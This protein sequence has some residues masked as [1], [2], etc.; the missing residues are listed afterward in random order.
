MRYA[1]HH[2]RP[3]SA[4]PFEL[5]R[6][7]SPNSLNNLSNGS[8]PLAEL[9]LKAK[10]S[11]LAKKAQTIRSSSQDSAGLVVQNNKPAIVKSE[12]TTQ[13]QSSELQS[14][15]VPTSTFDEGANAAS[16]LNSFT[17]RTVG[18]GSASS[19]WKKPVQSQSTSNG[20]AAMV[21][22]LNG[23]KASSVELEDLLAEGR[24]AAEKRPQHTFHIGSSPN[25]IKHRS[26]ASVDDGRAREMRMTTNMT[27]VSDPEILALSRELRYDCFETKSE[28]KSDIVS[29]PII[30]TATTTALLLPTQNNGASRYFAGPPTGKND[31]KRKPKP[32]P[33]PAEEPDLDSSSVSRNPEDTANPTKLPQDNIQMAQADADADTKDADRHNRDSNDLIL[34][35]EHSH[36][37]RSTTNEVN[38][39]QYN[40]DDVEEWLIMTGFYDAP[41]RL[42]VLNR[43]RRMKAIEEEKMQLLLEEQADQ[44][45]RSQSVVPMN[46]VPAAAFLARPTSVMAMPPPPTAP[47]P[48]PDLGLRIKDAAL[49][50]EVDLQATKSPKIASNANSLKRQNSSSDMRNTAEEQSRKV[51]R[52]N[53]SDQ[54]PNVMNVDEAPAS[55]PT[56]HKRPPTSPSR[57]RPQTSNNGNEGH[58]R[59]LGQHSRTDPRVDQDTK[60]NYDQWMPD[61]PAAYDNYR[62]TSQED[63]LDRPMEPERRMSRLVANGPPRRS[64]Q[65]GP[66]YRSS[67]YGEHGDFRRGSLD[68]DKK[69]GINLLRTRGVRYFLIKSWNYENI[70][71][72]QR[73]CTWCTQT[74][75]EELFN[76]AFNRSTHVIL[77]FSANNSHAFQGYARMLCLPGEPGVADPSWR[78]YLHWPT[79]KPFRI[80]WLVK[81]DIPY[82]VAGKLKNPLN[83]DTPV[84]VGRDGQEIPD[85]IGLELCEAIEADANKFRSHGTRH[86]DY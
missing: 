3:A 75:N 24:A 78:K 65:Q 76:D 83:E 10:E 9:K 26:Q 74:K 15:A 4:V 20:G 62:R 71:T 56:F 68:P 86:L 61:K 17:T 82:R 37:P 57:S 64:D 77:I 31:L 29:P 5:E 55:S 44:M 85:S 22:N 25:A 12:T 11:I 73:E 52:T 49:K 70:E 79:T 2:A 13:D 19:P 7:D 35:S 48:T 46:V 6:T 34:A 40:L 33:P 81:G 47:I 32:I 59:S 38:A 63:R 42:K 16:K 43:R 36:L 41:Y 58:R 51:M 69:I 21:R 8:D 67:R 80:S 60:R 30:E 66:D 39:N 53:S 18:T 28:G 54:A 14:T 72:A 45:V 50:N 1:A 27:S 84:F 23:M